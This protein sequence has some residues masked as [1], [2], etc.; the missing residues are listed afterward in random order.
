ML[1]YLLLFGEISIVKNK[2]QGKNEGGSI[3]DLHLVLLFKKTP[4]AVPPSVSRTQQ[5][6]KFVDAQ[7]SYKMLY[8]VQIMYTHVYKCKNDTC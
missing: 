1:F 8:M 4:A 6:P 5:I 3:S 7:G 2:I